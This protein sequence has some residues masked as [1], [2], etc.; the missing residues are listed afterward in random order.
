MQSTI[1]PE[2]PGPFPSASSPSL[3]S[4]TSE[5]ANDP[6]PSLDFSA[7]LRRFLYDS[8]QVQ[9]RENQI[10]ACL[11][12][13]NVLSENK[14]DVKA[15]RQK[16]ED[17]KKEIQDIYATAQRTSLD[18]KGSSDEEE[19]NLRMVSVCIDL[20]TFSHKL[21]GPQRQ[22]SLGNFKNFPVA[23]AKE[24]RQLIT[25]Y[26]DQLKEINSQ[27]DVLGE[28]P[29]KEVFKLKTANIEEKLEKIRE[30][31][32]N[33]GLGHKISPEQKRLQ[34]Q[35]ELLAQDLKSLQGTLSILKVSNTEAL[36]AV[37]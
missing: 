12:R 35:L 7:H 23:K 10:K 9:K 22:P 36:T 37:T 13:I 24:I 32:M 27:I 3:A 2:L 26:K 20:N 34:S 14:V 16:V 19:L 33:S 28:G 6:N 18:S 8:D 17:I 29:A 30:T 11:D 21:C 4:A 15:L 25:E 31:N 5:P 1:R